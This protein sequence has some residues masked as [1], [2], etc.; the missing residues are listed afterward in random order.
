VYELRSVQKHWVDLVAEGRKVVEVA[1]NLESADRRL[2][3]AVV[4]P[5]EPAQHVLPPALSRTAR[6]PGQARPVNRITATPTPEP[7]PTIHG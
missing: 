5:W 3:G 7:R 2:G 1:E 4:P 6:P